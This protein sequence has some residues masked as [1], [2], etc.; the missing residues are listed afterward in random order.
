[1]NP[2]LAVMRRERV[3]SRDR[4][5]LGV[6]SL[7]AYSAVI[8][9]AA[10]LARRGHRDGLRILMYHGV[11]RRRHGPVS[12]G[13]LFVSE[14]AFARHMRHLRQ[15]FCPISLDAALTAWITGRSLPPR[16]V[17][18]TFDDGYENVLSVALPIL[19]RYRIPATVF[20]SAAAVGSRRWYWFDALRVFV[21]E[22]AGLGA[23]IGSDHDDVLGERP[24]THPER[25]FLRGLKE[26][27]QRPRPEREAVTR[28]L[29][30]LGENPRWTE[31]HPEFTLANW[32]QWRQAVAG[33]LIDIG[34]HGMNHGD[35]LAMSAQERLADL[36]ASKRVIEHELSR[37]CRILAYPHGRWDASVVEATREAGYSCALTTDDGLN[38]AQRDP[39]TWQ[40]T[41]I[42]DKGDFYLF[43]A[44]VC[45]LWD[46]A[47][48]ARP[49]RAA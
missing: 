23:S 16:A 15:A 5:V 35:L 13:N 36:Q 29:A 6:K 8:S 40:R 32:T 14:R 17:A 1:M 2:S 26:I 31:Q 37:P 7:I 22:R 25:A 46:R 34:S 44:R 33:G 47:R 21:W 38:D 27:E 11:V 39:L 24:I 19:Q 3:I 45:G 9:G 28:R 18:V 48:A 30:N 43:C 12:F 20:V 10:A 4:V 42:G 49:A 41:M